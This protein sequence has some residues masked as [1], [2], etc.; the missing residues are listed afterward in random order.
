MTAALLYAAKSTE[1][2]HGSIPTQLEDCR[3]LAARQGWT[4]A[5]EFTDEAFSAY[6]ANRG[7]G[8]AKA[9]ALAVELAREHGAAVLI[10]QDA[11][12]FARGAGDAPGAADHLGELYFAMRRQSVALWSVRSGEL[13][14]L[15]AALEG[16]RATDESARKSQ[17]VRAGLKRRKDSNKPVGPVRS[18][19]SRRRLRSTARS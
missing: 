17:S 2:V 4:V 12:R 11:D 13:D 10:A 9:K 7:P 1:D 15:R 19:T 3:A 16:E 8:L 5:A 18:A 14:L 6:K